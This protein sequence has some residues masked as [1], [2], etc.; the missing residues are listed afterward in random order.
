MVRGGLA[1]CRAAASH[2]PPGVEI[3]G[4]VCGG[5]SGPRVMRTMLEP[6]PRALRACHSAGFSPLPSPVDKTPTGRQGLLR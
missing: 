4:V 5:G 6:L 3:P 1:R 2:R